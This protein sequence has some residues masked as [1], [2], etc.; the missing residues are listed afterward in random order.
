[1]K[2]YTYVNKEL[3]EINEVTIEIDS[4]EDLIKIKDFFKKTLK[5]M[6]KKSDFNHKHY[7]DFIK[8]DNTSDIILFNSIKD[9][10]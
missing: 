6:K 3:K 1:M 4:K 5:K 10:E 9:K 8:K 7:K 2:L